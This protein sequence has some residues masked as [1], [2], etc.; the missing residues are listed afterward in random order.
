MLTHLKP[1]CERI[2]YQINH[3]LIKE[4]TLVFQEIID[5]SKSFRKYL[6]RNIINISEREL[7]S[8]I[9]DYLL[10]GRYEKRI[11]EIIKK[12]TGIKSVIV[13][14]PPTPYDTNAMMYPEIKGVS[15]DYVAE[16][17]DR[18]SGIDNQNVSERIN[19][20][21]LLLAKS[22]DEQ[23]ARFDL[24]NTDTK[25][26]LR[27]WLYFGL[28]VV[29]TFYV[30]KPD[31]VPFTASEITAIT[32][33]EIGHIFTIVN[34][35]AD[36]HYRARLIEDTI[37][38]YTDHMDTTDKK[39][40]ADTLRLHNK[41]AAFANPSM[42]DEELFALTKLSLYDANI[43]AKSKI[44]VEVTKLSDFADSILNIS[45][46]ER[47]ADEYASRFGMS[48]Y[49]A[50][51]LTKIYTINAIGVGRITT[52]IGLPN[53]VISLIYN[54]SEA[55]ANYESKIDS[56][57]PIYDDIIVRLRLLV[58]NNIAIF[59]NQDLPQ[60]IRAMYLKITE[61]TLHTIEQYGK[62][63]YVKKRI[64]IYNALQERRD[65]SLLQEF[66]RELMNNKLYYRAQ[67]IRD[68]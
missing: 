1:A 61:D 5:T 59:K 67:Q 64:S 38:Y 15:E 22:T 33:H 51:A 31:I 18:L 3:P 41:N 56:T 60:D 35:I 12:H 65:Y 66:T 14:I 46:I 13:S 25:V 43:T 27:L 42:T 30:D 52:S 55:M 32:L 47:I 2:Y 50:S 44:K 58:Q 48:S 10:E 37:K 20:T 54:I 34:S 4:L 49:L 39:K 45:H 36:M 68:I 40:I 29:D 26:T 23:T 7:Q 57:P 11:S 8:K 6:T 62:V 28:F 9:E 16:A 21:F 24:N 53:F 63:A 17:Y 19:N